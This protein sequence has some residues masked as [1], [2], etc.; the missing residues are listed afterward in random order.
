MSVGGSLRV[1]FQ[2]N[3]CSA[4]QT[5]TPAVRSEDVRGSR[6]FLTASIAL[7]LRASSS[8]MVSDYQPH[9]LKVRKVHTA[10]LSVRK[11]L[12]SDIRRSNAIGTALPDVAPFCS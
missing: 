10:N 4:N 1:S 5:A 9:C 8:D 11:S 6:Y 2:P 7:F 12:P 3:S